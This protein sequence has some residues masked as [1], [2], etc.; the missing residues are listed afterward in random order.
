VTSRTPSPNQDDFWLEFS[1]PGRSGLDR[2]DHDRA[3]KGVRVTVDTP[4]T[5]KA[6]EIEN[7]KKTVQHDDQ[8]I[9]SSSLFVGK[10][11]IFKQTQTSRFFSAAK[12]RDHSKSIGRQPLL[13]IRGL[14]HHI[15]L[16]QGPN[17]EFHF[18]EFMKSM[19][20]V[21]C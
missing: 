10:I 17:M 15:D 20:R 19:L 11:T 2:P 1:V 14:K 13:L 21:A 5:P 6:Q 18:L 12:P 7:L 3:D 4:P 9:W 16:L 8:D